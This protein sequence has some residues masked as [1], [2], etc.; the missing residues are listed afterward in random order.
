MNEDDAAATA[1]SAFEARKREMIHHTSCTTDA[2]PKRTDDWSQVD[3][4]TCLR[5]ESNPT[6]AR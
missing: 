1:I 3:C 2:A 6:H 5:S 4:P